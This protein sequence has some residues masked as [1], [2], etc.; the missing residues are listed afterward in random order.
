MV[1][2]NE[3]EIAKVKL[4]LEEKLIKR[5]RLKQEQIENDTVINTLENYLAYLVGKP[6]EEISSTKSISDWLEYILR[7]KGL[8]MRVKDLLF[9]VRQIPGLEHTALQTITGVLIR[10]SN[11]GKR[12]ERVAP[13][14]YYILEEKM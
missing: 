11:K 9:E 8:P 14:T 3:R 4:E 2:R 7:E 12:F 1:Q 6:V 10:Y 5:R 13:N